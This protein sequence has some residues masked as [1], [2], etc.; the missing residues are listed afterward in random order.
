MKNY[1]LVFL[2]PQSV[3]KLYFCQ[4]VLLF[5]PLPKRKRKKKENLWISFI[6]YIFQQLKSFSFIVKRFFSLLGCKLCRKDFR[7]TTSKVF[8]FL[9]KTIYSFSFLSPSFHL[10]FLFPFPFFKLC[11]FSH[12]HH[13][14]LQQVL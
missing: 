6:F 8:T 14:L 5:A 2:S 12:I 1:S 3:S 13:Y 7:P 10:N 4:I 11:S 9:F